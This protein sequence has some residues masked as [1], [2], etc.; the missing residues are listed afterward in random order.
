M[1]R[2]KH[3]AMVNEDEGLGHDV[4]RL[5]LEAVNAMSQAEAA[6]RTVW[7]ATTELNINWNRGLENLHARWPTRPHVANCTPSSVWL[8]KRPRF[9]QPA[10]RFRAA[11]RGATTS[12]RRMNAIWACSRTSPVSHERQAAAATLQWPRTPT[13]R[14][15]CGRG[16]RGEGGA[17]VPTMNSSAAA[18]TRS[19]VAISKANCASCLRSGGVYSADRISA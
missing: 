13:G 14:Q 11:C 6:E 16:S 15:I 8:N 17:V 19:V 4:E 18:K 1:K 3:A 5:K 7:S 2:W 12:W 10:D 9:V